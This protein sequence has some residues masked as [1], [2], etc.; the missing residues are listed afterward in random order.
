MFKPREQRTNIGADSL[1]PGPATPIVFSKP[2][3]A[4]GA[5]FPVYRMLIGKHA[6]GS[7]LPMDRVLIGGCPTEDEAAA[8][9]QAELKRFQYSG[10]V[11]GGEQPAFWARNHGEEVCWQYWHEADPPEKPRSA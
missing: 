5:M 6:D 1:S 7:N 9:I 3:F 8:L 10:R 4:E 11:D 2:F